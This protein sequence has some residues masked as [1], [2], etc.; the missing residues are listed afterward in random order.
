[1]LNHHGLLIQQ[2]VTSG[3]DER[4]T[5]P[6]VGAVHLPP[7]GI[8]RGRPGQGGGMGGNV[9]AIETICIELD[10]MANAPIP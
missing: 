4:F 6:P 9:G 3:S 1:M 10:G 2:T 5:G 8:G 7:G